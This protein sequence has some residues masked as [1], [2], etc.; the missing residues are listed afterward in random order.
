MIRT[1]LQHAT[2]WHRSILVGLVLAVPTLAAGQTSG[3]VAVAESVDASST[4]AAPTLVA[5]RVSDGP[6]IDGR[7]DEAAWVGA[8]VATGFTQMSPNPGDPASQRTEARILYGDG[9]IF[10]GIKL[11]DTHPDSIVAQLGR[12]DSQVYSD[13]VFV[14]LDSYYDRRTAFT[15]GLN[16]R[17]VMMDV[18]L[19]SDTDQDDSWDAVWEGA[20]SIVDDGWIA[21]FRIPLSQL[22]FSGDEGEQTWGVNFL[23]RIARNGEESVWSPTPPDG[24][25]LVS[26]FGQLRGLRD[27]DPP[28]RLELMPYSVAR[29]TLA[30]G[31]AENPFYSEADPYGSLGADLKAG[32]TSDLTLTATLN[33]DFGQ[34]EADP[35]V[36]NL[37]AFET[38]FPEKRPFFVEGVDIFRFGIGLGDG[39][40][41]NESLFYSRRIGRRPQG[42]A[43]GDYV[44]APDATTILGAAK[45]SGKTP[46]GWSIGVLSAVTAEEQARTV[47]AS[48]GLR[49]R[50]VIEPLTSYGMARVIKDFRGG[51]SAVGAVFTSTNRA[52]PDDGSLDFLRSD[53][54]SGG[55]DARHR[56]ADGAYQIRASFVGSHIQGPPQAIDRVQ[57]SPVHY[58]Q[59]PDAD[60]LDY[61]AS[62][63]SLS[64][65]AAK[66]ELMKLRGKWRF[67]AFAL[68]QSPGFEVNDLGF[69]QNSDLAITGFWGGYHQYEAGNL[70]RSWNINVN[71]WTGYTYGGE[72]VALGGNVNAGARFN[73]LW[74]IHGGVN[75]ELG[76]LSPGLLRGGPAFKRPGGLNWW[77]GMYTDD[78][79]AV[80]F[81]FNVSGSFQDETDGRRIS[82]SP[83]IT[84][85]PSNNADLRIGPS[86]SWNRNALQYVGERDANGQSYSLLGTVDQTTL[87]LTARLNYTFSPTL[88][89]QF[90]AQPF[91]SAGE[92]GNFRYVADP[93]AEAYA[94]R[95]HTLTGSEIQP[96]TDADGAITHVVDLDRDGT[97]DFE[98]R[99]P[100]FNFKQLRSNLVLRWEYLPGS[101]LFVV[102]SQGRTDYV[103]DGRLRFEQDVDRLLG[104]PGTNVLLIKASYWLGL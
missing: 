21:E 42:H 34:V 89:L 51:Q 28:R 80:N 60:H 103:N 56:F 75:R 7:L 54:Y 36:V 95:V 38:F 8:D 40:L 24:S 58:F 32:I 45:L 37:T 17:G 68:T 83:G 96:V 20:V 14:A 6:Y 52:R 25:A 104:A 49:E 22:R 50:Q 93:R 64:G 44:D 100:S 94:D 70:F 73:N 91:I 102:W 39:D 47:D 82:L 2:P 16:P 84:V 19:H 76:V 53:A 9:A 57:T 99:D 31:D 27:L 81:D 97:D 87:A 92:Y 77:A 12:R 35:S 62:R 101:T 61:D 98:F 5:E 48:S 63:T 74:G 86:I 30:P 4:G 90:Y 65:F 1:L 15:F 72:H 29:M 79:A 67:A 78:R 71:G 59:R 13:W 41:G 69:Q 18:L 33:P 88:S 43:D 66:A 11:Y 10:I 85:R 26:A 23:R 55:I 3:I 46:G